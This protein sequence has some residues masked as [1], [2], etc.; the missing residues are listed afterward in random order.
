[1]YDALAC[2]RQG[3]EERVA[4]LS[5]PEGAEG[6]FVPVEFVAVAKTSAGNVVRRG[7]RG[8]IRVLP[9]RP[10][11]PIRRNNSSRAVLRQPEPAVGQNRILACAEKLLYVMARM[12]AGPAAGR[13][14]DMRDEGARFLQVHA[15]ALVIRLKIQNQKS[16]RT[17]IHKVQEMLG[18]FNSVTAGSEVIGA[19]Q[20]P[21]ARCIRAVRLIGRIHVEEALRGLVDDG[22]DLALVLDRLKV[23]VLVVMR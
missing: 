12:Q 4:A 1:M 21:G 3:G 16:L 11:I 18:L 23:Q 10:G 20:K 2:G 7:S 6:G 5:T 13:F 22:E 14:M 8:A 15:R 9:Q 17:G 19:P